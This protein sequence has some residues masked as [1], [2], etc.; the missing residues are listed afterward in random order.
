MA[1]SLNLDNLLIIDFLAATVFSSFHFGPHDCF[2]FFYQGLG[3]GIFFFKL[4]GVHPGS[5]PYHMITY[6]KKKIK[7][8]RAELTSLLLYITTCQL[9][10][11]ILLVGSLI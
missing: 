2:G 7:N 1:I 8:V 3:V 6:L 9:G 11:G 10:P 5:S 4:I